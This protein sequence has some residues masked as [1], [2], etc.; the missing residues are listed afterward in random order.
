MEEEKVEVGKIITRAKSFEQCLDYEMAALYYSEAAKF[1]EEKSEWLRAAQL[2]ER[3]TDCLSIALRCGD[4]SPK[5]GLSTR[6]ACLKAEELYT[7]HGTPK[8]I[9]RIKKLKEYIDSMAKNT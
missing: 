2:F 7:K 8:D 1:L 5:G 4:L 9:N 3:E 6:E